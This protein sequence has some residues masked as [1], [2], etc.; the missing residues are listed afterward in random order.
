MDAREVL[1][2]MAYE[3]TIDPDKNKKWIKDIEQ[4][5]LSKLADS[6]RIELIRKQFNIASGL[7]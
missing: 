7:E 6:E 1:K 4:E 3:L 5:R 2:W